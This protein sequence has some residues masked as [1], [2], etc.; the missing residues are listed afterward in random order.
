MS[1]GRRI[2]KSLTA[3][4]G[5]DERK[6]YFYC[7]KLLAVLPVP[8]KSGYEKWVF[9]PPPSYS[10]AEPVAYTPKC[11]HDLLIASHATTCEHT[12]LY[13]AFYHRNLM[14]LTEL[15]LNLAHQVLREGLKKLEK[16]YPEADFY[17]GPY[18]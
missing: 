15:F 13:F 1:E 9:Y 4:T 3:L 17:R 10:S 5:T 7:L 2:R 18:K 11:L 12:S 6:G 14:I 8:P 16:V